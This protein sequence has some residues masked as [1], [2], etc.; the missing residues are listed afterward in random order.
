MAKD[1]ELR[2]RAEE[3]YVIDGLTLEE[4]AKETGVPERTIANWSSEDGWKDKQKEYQNALGEIKRYTMLTRLKLIKNAMTSLDPQKI[5]AFAALER[6]VKG[7]SSDIGGYGDPPYEK[8]EIKTPQDAID[9][10]QEALERKLNIMLS[11]PDA[12]NFSGVKDVK[13]AMDL[14]DELKAKYTTPAGKEQKLS[15]ASAATIDSLR[16][17]IMKEI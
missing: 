16:D 1:F 8:R 6:A 11:Q 13:Q 3:L 10:L 12:I 4:V 17:A 14:V 9:A 5:Y 2:Q 7:Q 15:G